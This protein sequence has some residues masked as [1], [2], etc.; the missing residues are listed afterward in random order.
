MTTEETQA[1]V[2]KIES[3]LLRV[4]PSNRSQNDPYTITYTRTPAA[5]VVGGLSALGL[6]AHL[7]G[8]GVAILRQGHLRWGGEGWVWTWPAARPVIGA[9]PV[10]A[11]IVRIKTMLDSYPDVTRRVMRPEPRSVPV[12]S[13]ARCAGT[14]P[15]ILDPV[16]SARMSFVEAM[17]MAVDL[18][19]DKGGV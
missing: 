6:D 8:H 12:V 10:A 13:L 17:D 16:A 4:A 11:S 2:S 14:S 3:L 18:D 9:G 7:C 1:L 19:G 5:R 15:S